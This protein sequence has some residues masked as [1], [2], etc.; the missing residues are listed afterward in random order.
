[1]RFHKFSNEELA[2]MV[3]P[4]QFTFPFFYT[5]HPLC[6][7]AAKHLQDYLSTRTEW[8]DELQ[9]GKMMGVLIVSRQNDT[10]CEEIGFLAAFSG[11]LAHS[12]NH[13]YFVPAVYDLLTEK[14]FFRPEEDNISEINRKINAE[15]NSEKRKAIIN[16]LADTEVEA[17]RAI[18]EYK[19]L[20]KR[21]KA[22]RDE[23]RKTGTPDEQLIAES[24]FQ[25]A[26][27]KRIQARW[28]HNI[29]ELKS[30]LSSSDKL[31]KDW[32]TERQRRSASLQERIFRHFIMLN[33]RGE[34]RDLYDIFAETPQHTP[35][36][37]AGECAAPKLLQYAFSHDMQ[38]LAM[39]EFWVGK[40]PKNEIRRHGNF[41]PS[42]KA[43]CEPILGWMLKGL[44]VEPNP[45]EK[46]HDDKP[47][48]IIFEDDW[49]LVVN[50][51]EG[52]LSVPG[53]LSVDSLQERVQ[54][55]YAENCT[56]QIIHRLD[57]ATS[58][59]LMFAKSQ[60]MHKIM[61]GLFKS[62]KVKKRY[63]A[64][65][66]G[67]VH[68]DSGIIRLPL[69]LNPHER[70]LQTVSHTHGKPA[71]TRYEVI[72]RKDGKT[73]IVFYPETGR[74]HQLRVHSA[75]PEGLNTPILGDRLYG[76]PAERLYLHAESLEFT[77]P[78]TGKHIAMTA[79]CPF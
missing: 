71:V 38:P 14:G 11:N 64:I 52:I 65:L 78:I 70:P 54:Q 79:P 37:G 30:Q 17:Q 60:T 51:P 16:W 10:L 32:K 57:M 31:I 15:L 46:R 58:G 13:D 23:L 74:T 44:D 50:K 40:S 76:T 75:H 55:L 27:L 9:Q 25:K 8:A 3:L 34:S 39:A 72:E 63:I 18:S 26:E 62:R 19:L 5:P 20:M 29:N 68:D 36:A 67:I 35:P 66:D 43:K 48:D 69:I 47:I 7:L 41:Y 33:A 53:K 22:R 2:G 1:M 42:C 49:L 6:I 24:Q 4:R 21:S 73:R 77:H 28:Q 56:P 61:Q 45:L 12:N 59:L